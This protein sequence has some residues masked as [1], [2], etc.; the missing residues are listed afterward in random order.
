MAI[1]VSSLITRAQIRALYCDYDRDKLNDALKYKLTTMYAAIADYLEAIGDCFYTNIVPRDVVSPQNR[2][3][4]LIALLASRGGRLTLAMHIYMGL[5]EGFDEELSDGQVTFDD[6]LSPEEIANIIF[7]VG[8]YTGSDN[9]ALGLD[10]LI[11]TLTKLAKVAAS[12]N[13][14]EV[15]VLKGLSEEFH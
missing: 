4:I 2:E 12:D 14:T 6:E 13:R 15:A 1:D 11:R 9:M 5:M 3:R 10:T 8:I 7:L